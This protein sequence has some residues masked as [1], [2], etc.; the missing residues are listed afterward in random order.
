MIRPS[1]RA[2]AQNA[3]R[4][5]N[6]ITRPMALV[7]TCEAQSTPV[8]G[9]CA[10]VLRVSRVKTPETPKPARRKKLDA[11]H[12]P[13]EPGTNQGCHFI[14]RLKRAAS[15]HGTEASA[16]GRST[17]GANRH[18]GS[19]T[20]AVLSDERCHLLREDGIVEPKEAQLSDLCGTADENIGAVRKGEPKSGGDRVGL[21]IAL[22]FGDLKEIPSGAR[23][24]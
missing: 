20:P 7:A 24:S 13:T 11:D 5:I 8:N 23:P 22:L 17:D 10:V 4:W 12:A 6:A 14:G 18:I 21:S 16:A 9:G 1:V 19:P 3:A 2:G 15:P